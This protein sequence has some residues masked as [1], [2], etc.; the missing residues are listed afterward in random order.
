MGEAGTAGL[1]EKR[2]SLPSLLD[3]S[4]GISA[5]Q[6][7]PGALGTRQ[8]VCRP[9]YRAAVFL[10]SQNALEVLFGFWQDK[11]SNKTIK[12]WEVAL[13]L[14]QNPFPRVYGK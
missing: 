14:G 4:L 3:A 1:W 11:S 8:F 9:E 2:W 6:P 10:G 12:T 7:S 5:T 13:D